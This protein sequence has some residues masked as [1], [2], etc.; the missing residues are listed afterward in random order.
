MTN[1]GF[2]KV[3]KVDDLRENEG[4][5]FLVDDVDVALFKVDGEIYALNNVCPHQKAPV[6]YDG[7]IYDGAVACPAHGWEFDLKTGKLGGK[8]KGLDCYEVRIQNDEIFVK[9]FKKEL[10]W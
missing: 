1:S 9:V 8:R 3:C 7:F 4:R 2:T 6:I 5:R 10:N